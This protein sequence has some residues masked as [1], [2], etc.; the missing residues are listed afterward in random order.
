MRYFFFVILYVLL[1]PIQAQIIVNGSIKE[2]GSGES[3]AYVRVFEA[4][5][6]IGTRANTYGYFSLRLPKGNQELEFYLAGYEKEML[7]LTLFSDTTLNISLSSYGVAIDTVEITAS[8]ALSDAGLSRLIVPIKQLAQVPMLA[9]EADVLKAMQLLPGVQFGKEGTTGLFIRGGSADQNLVL[10]DDIPI[11][12]VS[13]L[14]GFASLFPP[15]SIK[16]AE[17]FKGGFPAEY[18]G[19]LSSVIKLQSKEGDLHKR[20]TQLSLGSITGQFTTEGPIVKGKAS[21]FVSARSTWINAIFRP[22]IKQVFKKEG[23]DGFLSYDFYD[24]VGK[25][26]YN[27]S[28]RDRLYV[29]FYTGRDKAASKLGS[30]AQDSTGSIEVNRN[31]ALEWG[32]I[33][34]SLRYH[35]ILGAKWFL[36]SILGY[37][38]YT[39]QTARSLETIDQRGQPTEKNALKLSFFSSIRDLHLQ[40]FFN[41]HPS[42]SHRLKFG[43]SASF[44]YFQPDFR[45]TEI[46]T[47]GVKVDSVFNND[48]IRSTTLVL[49]GED[50]WQFTERLS[51]RGGLRL[52]AFKTQNFSSTSLQPRLSVQYQL[53]PASKLNIS[54]SFIQQYLH[55]LS[56]SGLGLPADLWVP[57][58]ASVPPAASHQVV[59]GWDSKGPLNS[60][61][62]IEAYYK[63]FSQV[64]EYKDGVSLFNDFDS[65]QNK[66]ESGKGVAYGLEFWL[67]KHSGR[68]N[69]WL[70]YSLAWNNRQFPTINQGRSFPFKYDR[71]HNLSLFL[72]YLM[73]KR[74]KSLSLTW[75]YLSGFRQTVPV[76][77][78]NVPYDL[79]TDLSGGT[80]SMITLQGITGF[81]NVLA[82]APTRNNYQLRPFHKLDIAYQVKKEKKGR[83]RTWS[84]GIYN[85]YG[86]RNPYFI[87][88]QSDLE[89]NEARMEY[90]PVNRLAEQSF[91]FWIPYISWTVAF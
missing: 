25:A 87:F 9:G 62:S 71:R 44:K 45:L 21:Y 34:A 64:I 23:I 38:Q 26:N 47:Q 4:T 57:A 17:I 58:T 48:R 85:L 81:G 24:L 78:A 89:Y 29:S 1:K 68:L 43:L 52:E 69:G 3:L 32:N 18:G 54:Y 86:R 33:A 30:L 39:Y 20:K 55:L 63:T 28:D 22:I 6:Q 8:E 67:R 72:S 73:K 77:I 35:K 76:G 82:Y 37:S 74:H 49:F 59:A 60:L 83:V 19:R 90:L 66:V 27:I 42:S 31:S 11:Y 50:E 88:F 80:E 12:N 53:S 10:L 40:Q 14:F 56:N 41:Y 84:Y 5:K 61:I 2:A 16:S 91:L 65:W 79:I 70:S 46:L 51:L 7:S 13:H 15:S 75:M 36:K